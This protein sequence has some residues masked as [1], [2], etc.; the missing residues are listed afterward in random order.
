MT[1]SQWSKKTGIPAA[2]IARRIDRGWNVKQ[3][4]G[5]TP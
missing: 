3:A 2:T 4:L 5:E 1:L